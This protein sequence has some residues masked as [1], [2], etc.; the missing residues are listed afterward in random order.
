[1][2]DASEIRF[3]TPLGAVIAHVAEQAERQSSERLKLQVSAEDVQPLLPPGRRVDHAVRIELSIGALD[4]DVA[5]RICFTLDEGLGLT[6]S[7]SSGQWLESVEFQQGRAMLSLGVRDQEWMLEY[8]SKQLMLPSR[9][10]RVDSQPVG[11][12]VNSTPYGLIID[13]GAL[14]RGETIVCPLALAYASE[15]SGS[16]DDASTWFGVDAV[17]P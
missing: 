6:G 7:S 8:G 10:D 9:L 2:R 11:Y 15:L 1:M 17:L 16:E 14:T 12:E 5:P 4:D 3:T 13:F